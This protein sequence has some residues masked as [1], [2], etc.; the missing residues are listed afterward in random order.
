MESSHLY[1]FV[2][3]IQQFKQAPYVGEYAFSHKGGLHASAVE[4]NPLTYEHINPELVGNSRNVIISDQAG[5]SNLLNQLKKM[6]IDLKEDKIELNGVVYKPY[7]I[8][9][10]PPSFG[11]DILSWINYRG[12]TYIAE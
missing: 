8:C 1:N 7:K 6:S 4:K 3:N 9:E 10:L 2:L 5:K 11:E 12:Y